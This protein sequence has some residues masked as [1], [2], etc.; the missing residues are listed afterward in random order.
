M[1]PT[2]RAPPA[3]PRSPWLGVRGVPAESTPARRRSDDDA[4]VLAADPGPDPCADPCADP[5]PR[6][7]GAGRLSQPAAAMR[8]CS[9]A[10]R[11]EATV[12]NGMLWSITVGNGRSRAR[13]GRTRARR[14][15]GG[16][17]AVT[18]TCG[19][20]RASLALPTVT[21]R[22]LPLPTVTRTCGRRRA[23]LRA[24][25]PPPAAASE[26]HP[27]A[28]ARPAACCL[29]P[30]PARPTP[31]GGAPASAAGEARRASGYRRLQGGYRAVT[32][33]LHAPA[34]EA[35]RAGG[36]RRLQG[37]YMAVTWR[38]HGGYIAVTPAG[39]LHARGPALPRRLARARPRSP[40]APCGR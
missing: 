6:E 19:R 30:R 35:R 2:T 27:T 28:P 8:R 21:Y 22:Y 7:V 38:L 40:A 11:A 39:G 20:R 25:T 34:G 1:P 4:P 10:L 37:G 13:R 36:Y 18:R 5:G 23:S 24:A 14:L 32:W 3:C 33:P 15:H 9:S 29:L 17:M 26:A 16:Y 12:G 31:A